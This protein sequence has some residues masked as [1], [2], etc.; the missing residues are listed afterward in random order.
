MRL[1][2]TRPE[3]DASKLAKRLE[4]LDHESTIEPLMSVSFEDTDPVDLSEAQ[5]VIATSRNG[6]AGLEAQGAHR[7]ARALPLF[8]VGKATARAARDLGFEL[9]VTGAGT[10]HDLVP[11]IVSACDPQAGFLAYLAGDVTS[12]DL[13][14]EL[15]PHGF[16]IDAPV[17][18]RMHA[19]EN[20]TDDTFEQIATGEIDGVL[21]FSPRTAD[22][23]VR[24]V[25]KHRLTAPA[26]R[27]THYCLSD[28]VARRLAPLGNIRIETAPAPNLDALLAL[29]V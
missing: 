25:R 29:L 17:V 2:I 20:F 7:I 9:I 3:P 24:L 10:V 5:A 8:A 26:S 27:M 13:R 11:Q 6:L 23:Y 22:I 12:V 15:E 18:Y 4:A 21:L 19:A 28:A 14:A 1:L 16:R